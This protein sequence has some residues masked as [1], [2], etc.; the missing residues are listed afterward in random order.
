MAIEGTP[1]DLTPRT[2][3][4]SDI[5]QFRSSLR[6]FDVDFTPL[7]RTISA[8][9]TVLDLVGCSVALTHSF[10]RIIDARVAP[11]C[12]AIGFTMDDGVPIRFNGVQRDKSIFVMGS[13]GAAYTS[14]ERI[15]RRYAAISFMPMI[16]NR[17]WPQ[18]KVNF[19]ILELSFAGYERLRELVRQVL[20]VAPQ[21]TNSFDPTEASAA[22]RES[23][24][25]GV[26]AALAEVIPTRWA[27]YANSARQFKIFRDIQ[28]VLSS[29]LGNP[30]YSD[31]LAREVG[32]SVRSLHDAVLRYRGMSLHRYLRLRRL[33][34]V[35]KQLLTGA[36]SVKAC[37]L[38]FGFWHLGDFSVSYRLHFGESPSETMAK[39]RTT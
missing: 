5:D 11:N 12:T 36:H 16:E 9:Q 15:E 8:E 26:D 18:A 14:V 29:N 38:A 25:A 21:L 30:I 10:P 23:L 7:A 1:R 24:L 4:F 20:A 31:A 13:D 27:T 28:A 3:R 32:I 22:I 35:R 6:S 17:G 33:W 19:Q 2:L 34:L 37:A 39:A